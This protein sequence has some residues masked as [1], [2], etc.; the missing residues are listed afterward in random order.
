MKQLILY[1]FFGLNMATSYAQTQFKVL[2]KDNTATPVSPQLMGSFY[3]L[4]FGRSDLLWGEMLFN[5]DFEITKPVSERNIW[6]AFSREAKEKEDWW[7]SGYEEPLWYIRKADSK[8][9]KLPLY[10]NNYWPSAHGKYFVQID[11]RKKAVSTQLSQDRIYLKKGNG[12]NF[13]GLFSAGTYFSDEK[14]AKNNV[15]VKVALYKEGDFNT[16]LSEVTIQVNTNQFNLYETKINPVAYEGWCTFVVDVPNNACVGIDFLSLTEENTIFGWKR[17]T[18]DRIKNEI[19]PRSIRFPGGCFASLY[20][21]RQG[22]GPREKRPVSYD[23]WWNCELVN[24]VGTVEMVQLC[25]Y[26]GAEPFFCVPVMFNDEFNAA[27]WVDFCNN[28]NN[29]RRIAYGYKEALNVKYWELEN[30]PYRRF[31]AITFANRCVAFAKAMKAKDPDIKI[32]IGNYWVFNKQF[33]KMLEIVGPYVDL[34]TNR[35]GTIGEMHQDLTILNKYNQEQDKSIR[36]CHTEFRAPLSREEKGVDGLNQL[37]NK[38]DETLFNRSVRW[39]YAMNMVDQYIQFQNM[40]S[41]F[42]TANFTNLT[43]GWGESLIN[44]AKEKCYLSA[45]GVAY[46]LLNSLDI[47]YPQQIVCANTKNEIVIQAAWNR[48]RNKLTLLL[49]NFN[50]QQ[51]QTCRIDLSSFK[52]SFVKKGRAY[53]IAPLFSGTFNNTLQPEAV[54]VEQI[55]QTISKKLNLKLHPMSLNAIEMEI[56]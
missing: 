5:R 14:Y 13:S 44:I 52:Q 4:G 45:A 27:E 55:E 49:L 24:D 35:G 34:I 15:P 8:D 21:W 32:A 18:V 38:D 56:K 33:E 19:K 48:S 9:E 20:D 36:L 30:E 47:A 42:Y 37:E 1:L 29:E 25:R 6:L 54:K 50:P 51:E 28:P 40:G 43:D 39:E 26:I 2:P 12:Y 53:R 31:D 11:N 7:H 16:P 17:E 46:S 23:T 22:V 10:S 3:E 41:Q